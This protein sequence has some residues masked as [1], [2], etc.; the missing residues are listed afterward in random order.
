MDALNTLQVSTEQDRLYST[1][2]NITQPCYPPDTGFS[3]TRAQWQ[4]ALQRFVDRHG[5]V[6]PADERTG[7]VT[8][9]VMAEEAYIVLHCRKGSPG[10][11]ASHMTGTWVVPNLLGQRDV[12]LVW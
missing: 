1:F 3:L 6:L 2:A 5:L 11:D 8:T 10:S 9:A 4:E 7:L 12:V